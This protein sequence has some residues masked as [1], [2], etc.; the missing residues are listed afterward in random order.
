[1]NPAKMVKVPPLVRLSEK[2][3]AD[4]TAPH[5]MGLD[6]ARGDVKIDLTERYR[7]LNE[8]IGLHSKS[9]RGKALVDTGAIATSIDINAAKSLNMEV[10]SRTLVQTA[11][12]GTIVAPM[13]S[14][15]MTFSGYA[16]VFQNAPGADLERFDLLAIIGRDILLHGVHN[17]SGVKGDWSFIIPN[18]SPA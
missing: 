17:Y 1:M 3:K 13:F 6:G 15:T 18:L 4:L 2:E 10:V 8:V 16:F 11:Y 5:L 9:L 12:Q 7:H 14:F